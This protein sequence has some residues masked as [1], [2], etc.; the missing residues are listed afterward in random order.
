[1]SKTDLTFRIAIALIM[2][3]LLAGPLWAQSPPTAE[4]SVA[5]DQKAATACEKSVHDLLAT[6]GAPVA[7]VKFVGSPTPQ[8]RLSGEKQIVLQ[9]AGSWQASSGANTFAYTCNVDAESFEVVGIV[10]RDTSPASSSKATPVRN[11][12]EP[13]LSNLSPTACESSVAAILRKRW[14]RV[15]E[16][17]FE[18]STRHLTQSG[19][20]M[21]ELHGRGRALPAPGAATTY[22]GFDCEIDSRDG[23]ILKT[24]VSN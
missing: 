10:M 15:S 9:G 16:V 18:S 22:F 24:Q 23:R 6:K 17:S 19:P 13:N 14:P 4:G 12:L 3:H 7:E 1:M 11:S 21:T 5:G 8:P 2:N 20:N